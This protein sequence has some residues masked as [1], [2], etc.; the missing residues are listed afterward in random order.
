MVRE[1]PTEYS[2]PIN[3]PEAVV[4][5]VNSKLDLESADQE[6]MIGIYLNTKLYPNV[7]QV[8]AI[9]TAET[10][11][12]SPKEIFKPAFLSSSTRIILAHNH[13]SGIPVPSEEDRAFTLRICDA[14]KLLGISLVDHLIIGHGKWY[15][16]R[17]LIEQFQNKRR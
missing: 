13:P 15:S 14:G 3:S 8:L 2:E 5:L 10:T 11:M 9:G 16:F 7:L 1:E 17:D 6:H 12:V 4:K